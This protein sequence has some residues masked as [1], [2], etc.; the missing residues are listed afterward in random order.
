[1]RWFGRVDTTD[2]RPAALLLVGQR[3]RGA[4]L[5]NVAG[6]GAR[7]HGAAP[8]FKTVIDGAPQ[9]AFTGRAGTATYMLATGLPPAMHTVEL[10][11]QTEGPQ[12]ES[13]L[14]SLTVGDGALMDPP[15]GASRLIEVIGDSITAA[16]ATSARRPT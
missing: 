4:L 2:H 14:M 6:R 7:D 9:A 12:G 13:R 1:V 3:L 15:A 5:G 10:Y 8:I 11:R 16:T